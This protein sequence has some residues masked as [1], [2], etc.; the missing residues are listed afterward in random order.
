[1]KLDYFDEL[2]KSKT[3]F[4]DE[5]KLDINYIP[6][7]LPH[8]ENEM[9]LLSQL[10][11]ALITNPNTISRKI[12]LTGKTGIGKTVTVKLFAKMLN[13]AAMRRNVKIK[14]IHVN[15]RKQRTSYKVLVKLIRSINKNFPKRGYSP[16]DL[17]EI[18]I[19]SLNKGD[20]HLLVILDELS[21]LMNNKED[22]IY[23]LTRIND[24]SFNSPQRISIIGI[25]RDIS[26]LNNLDS[27]TLSTLQQNIIKFPSYS[28]T[29]IFN[30]LSYRSQ[31]SLGDKVLSKNLI[32]MISNIVYR[33]G[34]DIRYGLNLIWRAGKI[35]ENRNLNYIDSECIR[36]GNSD[37]IPSSTQDVI[38]FMSLHKLLLLLGIIR[39][40]KE[41]DAEQV[42][43]IKCIEYYNILCEN[44]SLNPRKYSQ[45]W[46]Y[47]N[48]FEKENLILINV[49]SE[50]IRGR[51]SFI[52][53]DEIP[54]ERFE[55]LIQKLL[56]EKGIKL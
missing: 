19:E 43:I 52:K 38:E 6:E 36:V 41:I 4:K 30:I 15:C 31:I 53:I 50:D 25:V 26:C 54:L 27:S 13:K 18:I 51:K 39:S 20:L 22:L 46:N 47:L 8:R 32:K 42:S 35:A 45:I 33:N 48:E 12:L 9:K 49:V 24:D 1:M 11:L 3:L 5:S 55:K 28:K 2:L 34:G 7:K 44:I 23:Y 37:L 14:Y 29:Q 16:H 40:L 17:L 10:F 21:Y 56:N